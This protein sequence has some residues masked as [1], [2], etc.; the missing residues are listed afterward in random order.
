MIAESWI[1]L[2]LLLSL[3]VFVFGLV[4]GFLYGLNLY[5][6][7]LWM[8]M[9]SNDAF[10]AT[11]YPI[12]LD[13]MPRRGDWV[14]NPDANTKG[15]TKPWFTPNKPLE[16]KLIDPCNHGKDMRHTGHVV[17]LAETPK[18]DPCGAF[19]TA[20]VYDS[21]VEA[22]FDDTR[23]PDG[24][25]SPKGKTGVGSGILNFK[26]D[27]VGHPIAHLFGSPLTAQYSY[28]PVAIGRARTM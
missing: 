28:R 20:R 1:A 4:G 19:Y 10:S 6:T 14:Q 3:F 27:G 13:R 17:M 7:C 18:L 23:L 25:P 24:K 22:H 21:A 5:V 9:S 12:G 26:V 11:I 15:N 8:D 2:L 16:P